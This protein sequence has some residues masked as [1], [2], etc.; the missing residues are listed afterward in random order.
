MLLE[1]RQGAMCWLQLQISLVFL[2][3]RSP[4]QQRQVS[5]GISFCFLCVVKTGEMGYFYFM[6]L[7]FSPALSDPLI[8]PRALFLSGSTG[9]LRASRSPFSLGVIASAR[10]AALSP[11]L[12]RYRRRYHTADKSCGILTPC[13]SVPLQV[14]LGTR[15][16]FLYSALLHSL[17]ALGVSGCLG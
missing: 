13:S 2:K 5:F 10:V 14:F 15:G 1:G 3:A 11:P 16:L 7:H 4:E 17:G 12:S 8:V 9:K 6:Q